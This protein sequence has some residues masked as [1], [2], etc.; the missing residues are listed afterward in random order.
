[1][2]FFKKNELRLLWPFYLD[3]LLATILYIFPAFSILYF[4]DIGLSLFQ[5]GL[6]GSAMSL[7][8]ILFE[9][10]TEFPVAFD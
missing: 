7:S 9:I 10:P 6:L 4:K 5:I 2:K 8:I 3:A 1:M